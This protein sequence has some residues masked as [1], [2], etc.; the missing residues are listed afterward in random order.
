MGGNLSERENP[1]EE[2]GLFPEEMSVYLPH[3]QRSLHPERQVHPD[4]QS[5]P[6]L[7]AQGRPWWISNSSLAHPLWKVRYQ[8]HLLAQ[9]VG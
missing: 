2:D 9:H 3:L 6:V 5:S 8:P 7:P 1:P 4:A